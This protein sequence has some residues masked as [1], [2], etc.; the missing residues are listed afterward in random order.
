MIIL[1]YMLKFQNALGTKSPT[2]QRR[3]AQKWDQTWYSA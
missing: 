3:F 2:S 1:K